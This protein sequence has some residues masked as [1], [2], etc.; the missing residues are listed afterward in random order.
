M[1]A[2]LVAIGA[3]AVSAARLRSETVDAW[4]SYVSAT[5]ARIAQEARSSRQ[6]LGIDFGRDAAADTRDVVAGRIVV[7]MM[8]GPDGENQHAAIPDGLVHHVRGDVLIPGVSVAQV[9]AELQARVPRQDDVA[10]ADV[11][12]RGP[13]WMR[14]YLR[15][16]RKG[17]VTVSYDTEHLVTFTRVADGRA[18]S[19]SAATW[20]AE[21]S[22]PDTP[23]E[24]LLAPGD[25]RGFLWRLNSYWR[26]EDVP[27]GVIAECESLSL[28]RDV[29][30]LL[31]YV[32]SPAIES[33]ARESMERTLSTL[34]ARFA[35]R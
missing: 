14:V 28:S 2:A 31:R 30:A 8:G 6:F 23:D 27:G 33:T 9:L 25:D 26:Y 17:F 34:R 7:R 22:A 11:L 32:V 13:D 10:R 35:A 15:I 3:A 4:S 12:D 16:T 18:M 24:R 19:T 5:E 1:S 29:P 20:I 21:V